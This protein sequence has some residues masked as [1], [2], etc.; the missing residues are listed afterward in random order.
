MM[1]VSPSPRKTL[2]RAVELRRQFGCRVSAFGFRRI[3]VLCPDADILKMKLERNGKTDIT[4][5]LR[6]RQDYKQIRNFIL[7]LIRWSRRDSFCA[8]SV[9]GCA[10][11]LNLTEK[12]HGKHGKQKEQRPKIAATNVICR[13][14]LFIWTEMYRAQPPSQN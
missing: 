5:K 7:T 1:S 12:N 4:R 3:F 2:V 6:L 10:G 11:E 9:G 8:G 13:S 14:K